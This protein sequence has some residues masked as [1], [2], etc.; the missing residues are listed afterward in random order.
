MLTQNVA[1]GEGNRPG[2]RPAPDEMALS[3]WAIRRDSV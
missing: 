3:R 1:A 2:G